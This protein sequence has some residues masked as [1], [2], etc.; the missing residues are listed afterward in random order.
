MLVSTKLLRVKRHQASSSGPRLR[1]EPTTAMRSPGRARRSAAISSISRPD[2]KV[3]APASNSISA[4]IAILL[5]YRGISIKSRSD[6]GASQSVRL[7]CSQGPLGIISDVLSARQQIP[8]CYRFQRY[9]F[10]ALPALWCVCSQFSRGYLSVG[11][12]ALL[13]ISQFWCLPANRGTLRRRSCGATASGV[14]GLHW[15]TRH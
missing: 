2:A 9:A 5:R 10:L 11:P 13:L 12:S 7:N 4:R 6:H 15:W 8:L 14:F 3:L 1:S